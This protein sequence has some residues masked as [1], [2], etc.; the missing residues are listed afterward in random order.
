VKDQL[1]KD[2]KEE[3][4]EAKYNDIIKSMILTFLT[5]YSPYG[6]TLKQV[7]WASYLQNATLYHRFGY[8]FDSYQYAKNIFN[9]SKKF[10]LVDGKLVFTEQHFR[11]PSG[12]PYNDTAGPTSV[13]PQGYFSTGSSPALFGLVIK[14]F[15]DDGNN[16]IEKKILYKGLVYTNTDEIDA[17]LGGDMKFDG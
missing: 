6:F 14:G 13:D 2:V 17:M 15:L 11:N 7:L 4:K 8:F 9:A 16:W 1:L 10:S 12:E 5:T 3:E